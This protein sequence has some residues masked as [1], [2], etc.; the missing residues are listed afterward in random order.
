MSWDKSIAEYTCDKSLLHDSTVMKYM[1]IQNYWTYGIQEDLQINQSCKTI[2][3][4]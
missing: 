4:V 2:I 3:T 1:G